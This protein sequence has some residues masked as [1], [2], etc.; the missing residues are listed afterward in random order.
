MNKE[1]AEAALRE[2]AEVTADRDN[3]IR[4]AHATGITKN[5]IHTISGIA[6]TTI[7]RVLKETP[8]VLAQEEDLP[9]R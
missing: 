8:R 6:R 1:S 3:R 4:R 9:G 5:R 2:Y 7:D